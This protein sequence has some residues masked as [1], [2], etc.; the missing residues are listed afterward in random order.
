MASWAV[1]WRSL[2]DSYAPE[3]AMDQ[4]NINRCSYVLIIRK[5]FSSIWTKWVSGLTF[6]QSY[7][8]SGVLSLSYR[9][10]SFHISCFFSVMSWIF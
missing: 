5:F 7:T 8:A 1:V 3:S 6:F 2:I 9:D 4:P 10:P